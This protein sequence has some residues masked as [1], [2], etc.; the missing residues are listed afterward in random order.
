MDA[1]GCA[2]RVAVRAR[3]HTD[4]VTHETMRL[5]LTEYPF[6]VGVGVG[7]SSLVKLKENK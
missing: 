2:M 5:R 4:S 6:D 7:A 3:V 1:C